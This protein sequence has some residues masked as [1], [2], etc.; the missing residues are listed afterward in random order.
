LR[1]RIVVRRE[2]DQAAV[3]QRVLERINGAI[4]P[5][6]TRFNSTGW[7]FGQALRA[8][9][10]YDIALAEPGV[11]WVDGVRLLVDGAPDKAVTSV[12]ADT[13][14]RTRGTWPAAIRCFAR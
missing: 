1:A 11:R 6:P 3:R 12:A 13:L 5:L 14:R 8:S 4:N 10:V 7:P 2:E 9:H